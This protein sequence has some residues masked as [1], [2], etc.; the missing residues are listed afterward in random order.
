MFICDFKWFSFKNYNNANEFILKQS[1]GN[2][3][4]FFNFMQ[5]LVSLKSQVYPLQI[6]FTLYLKNMYALS[7]NKWQTRVRLKH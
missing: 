2:I 1:C 4:N 3:K 7:V 6:L 5:L